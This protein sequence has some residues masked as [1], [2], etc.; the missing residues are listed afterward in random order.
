[1]DPN[2]NMNNFSLRNSNT[3]KDAKEGMKWGAVVGGEIVALPIF[4]AIAFNVFEKTNRFF[5]TSQF[6]KDCDLPE[7]RNLTQCTPNPLSSKVGYFAFT[8]M[9]VTTLGGAVIGG[10]NGLSKDLSNEAFAITPSRFRR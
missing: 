4:S 1:M 2:V 7:F 8:V 9:V 6:E 3:Y 5:G 10:L